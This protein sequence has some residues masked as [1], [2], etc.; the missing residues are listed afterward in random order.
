MLVQL[1]KPKI[2][3][4]VILESKEGEKTKFYGE[5]QR[6]RTIEYKKHIGQMFESD[7]L[8]NNQFEYL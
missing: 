6:A 7:Y 1:K 4:L 8:Q 5:I 2:T 3:L